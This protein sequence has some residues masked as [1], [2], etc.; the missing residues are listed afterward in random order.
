MKKIYFSTEFLVSTT[1][2]LADRQ[3]TWSAIFSAT[4]IKRL[5][6]QIP[7]C[8]RSF[9]TVD[10]RQKTLCQGV[11][12][13]LNWD[14]SAYTPYVP[15]RIARIKP[16]AVY[17]LYGIMSEEIQ[18]YLE[19]YVA[20]LYVMHAAELPLPWRSCLPTKKLRNG[21]RGVFLDAEDA[22][23]CSWMMRMIDLCDSHWI[24][25]LSKLKRVEEARW[26]CSGTI[27]IILLPI[28]Q[29]AR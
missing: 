2:R 18:P 9:R 27:Y 17:I 20:V 28:S 11:R 13:F 10:F 6:Y 24:M 7:S 4:T 1:E 8:E 29:E 16:C 12:Y 3:P 25:G 15:Q 19:S 21:A 14:S 5:T 22:K 26:R 23:C